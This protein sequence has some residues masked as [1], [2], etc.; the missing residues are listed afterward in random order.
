MKSGRWPEE[1]NSDALTHEPQ[2]QVNAMG[3][4]DAQY[5]I[6]EKGRAYAGIPLQSQIEAVEV[7]TPAGRFIDLEE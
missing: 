5:R 6:T 4:I 7:S 3:L 2:G 1:R